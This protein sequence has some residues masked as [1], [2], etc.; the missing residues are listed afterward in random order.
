MRAVVRLAAGVGRAAAVLRS[1]APPAGR[2]AAAVAAAAPGALAG[3]R[4]QAAGARW[5]GVA[6]QLS[7]SGALGEDDEDL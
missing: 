6:M 2:L 3:G 4:L 7:V 5:R 1:A